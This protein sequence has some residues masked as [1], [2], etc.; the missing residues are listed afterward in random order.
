M[1]QRQVQHQH[2]DAANEAVFFNK[3]CKNE[4]R[5][6]VRQDVSLVTVSRSLTEYTARCYCDQTVFCLELRFFVALNKFDVIIYARHHRTSAHP[7][8]ERKCPEKQA[9]KNQ[10]HKVFHRYAANEHDQ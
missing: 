4:I 6:W 3:N 9:N 5:E 10:H 2:D 7:E 1:E 8:L